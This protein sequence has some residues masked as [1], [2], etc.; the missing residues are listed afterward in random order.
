MAGGDHLAPRPDSD[1]EGAGAAAQNRIGAVIERL[2]GWNDAAMT[3]PDEG[4]R[5]AAWLAA[6]CAGRC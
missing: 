3:D 4:V 6:R 1:G 5:R 2:K